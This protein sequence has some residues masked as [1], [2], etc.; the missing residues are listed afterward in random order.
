MNTSVRVSVVYKSFKLICSTLKAEISSKS[1]PCN[2]CLQRLLLFCSHWVS[3][4]AED[5]GGAGTSRWRQQP[6][7]RRYRVRTRRD[8]LEV[9]LMLTYPGFLWIHIMSCGISNVIIGMRLLQLCTRRAEQMTVRAAVASED[10]LDTN[11]SQRW[12]RS[13]WLQQMG[14]RQDNK[15]EKRQECGE[16]AWSTGHR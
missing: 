16:E 4:P 7:G 8:E 9:V 3:A 1:V 11:Q 10:F 6:W 2:D 15:M 13:L 5:A 14:R 12:H